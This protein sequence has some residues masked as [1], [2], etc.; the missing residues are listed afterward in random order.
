MVDFVEERNWTRLSFYFFQYRA[1]SGQ[2]FSRKTITSTIL[3]QFYFNYPSN[4]RRQWKGGV[5]C[6][7]AHNKSR[8]ALTLSLAGKYIFSLFPTDSI[9]LQHSASLFTA[10]QRP[11]SRKLFIECVKFF[12]LLVDTEKTPRGVSPDLRWTAG[13]FP[14]SC[15]NMKLKCSAALSDRGPTWSCHRFWF[16]YRS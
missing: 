14:P 7:R 4:H 8:K 2:S 11:A 13:D 1:P 10:A 6:V 9:S 15:V 3:L 12:L 5:E 16:R